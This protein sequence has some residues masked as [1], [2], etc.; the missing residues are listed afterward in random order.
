MGTDADVLRSAMTNFGVRPFL[1]KFLEL[2]PAPQPRKLKDG[3]VVMPDD[4]NFS[5]F[6]FK[7]PGQHESGPSRPYQFYAHLLRANLRRA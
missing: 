5:A 1:E 3:G 6:I 4:E 7:I 2:S